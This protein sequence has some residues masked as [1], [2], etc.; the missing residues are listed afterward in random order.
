MQQKRTVRHLSNKVP[1]GVVY[2][3]MVSVG[4][5]FVINGFRGVLLS[6]HMF[7]FTAGSRRQQG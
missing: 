2:G 7:V 1:D 6:G 5:G 4:G 3:R